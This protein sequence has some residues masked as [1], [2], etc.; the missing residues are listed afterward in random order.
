MNINANLTDLLKLPAKIIVALAI[1]TGIILFLPDS[2]I[3]KMYMT[4]FRNAYGF[5]IGLVFVISVSISL[6]YGVI[7]LY[8]FYSKK[9]YKHK[10]MK[11]AVSYL[12]KLT[13]YQKFIIYDLYLED[14]FTEE[15]PLHDGAVK[16]LEHNMMIGKAT[17]QYYVEDFNNAMF[18]YMLQPW[19]VEKLN[20]NKELTNGF[21]SEYEKFKAK[22]INEGR[23]YND[24]R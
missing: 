18:P 1:A 23:M 24:Y 10:F 21:K 3:N 19:V 15:L 16:M 11:N 9:Y 14:N 2:I 4:N 5:I 12:K 22:L 7:V 13:P 6:V 17:T 20:E 8:S